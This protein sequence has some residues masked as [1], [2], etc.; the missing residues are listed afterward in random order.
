MRRPVPIINLTAVDELV[1][2]D[3]FP[4]Y[5]VQGGDARRVSITTLLNY[6]LENLPSAVNSKIP[7][8]AAPSATGFS[9][10]IAPPTEGDSMW[11]VLTP[12]AAYATGT[13]VLPGTGE[14]VD[15]QEVDVTTTQ[16]V[17]TLTVSATGVN[18]TGAP[19]TLAQY[20]TFRMRYEGVTGTW[21]PAP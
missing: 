12:V 3:N 14:A 8:F 20:G 11:L 19:S 17:T 1:A 16:A 18:V 4:I 9:V 5:S 13:I 6:I 7:Q 2:G 10:T 15:G 21:Y